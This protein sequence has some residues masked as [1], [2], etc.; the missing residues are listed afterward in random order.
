[1]PATVLH[2]DVGKIKFFSSSH[3]KNSQRVVTGFSMA[4]PIKFSIDDAVQHPE[5]TK[6]Y[7]HIRNK[8]TWMVICKTTIA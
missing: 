8:P 5:D 1:V 6:K 4:L 3:H 7:H 2:L